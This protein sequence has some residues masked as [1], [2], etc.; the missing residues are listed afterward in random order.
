[1][2][3]V[4]FIIGLIIGI[5][6]GEGIWRGKGYNEGFKDAEKK[7]KDEIFE[8]HTCPTWVNEKFE[9]WGEDGGRRKHN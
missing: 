7:L 1:M 8:K 5:V 6:L 4:I 3:I 2:Q 9:N